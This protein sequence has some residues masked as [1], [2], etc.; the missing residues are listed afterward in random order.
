MMILRTPPESQVWVRLLF[1]PRQR[2]KGWTRRE[3]TSIK[4]IW[5]YQRLSHLH[6]FSLTSSGPLMQ[7]SYEKTIRRTEAV[8]STWTNEAEWVLG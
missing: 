2:A 8:P 7:Q 3:Y 4:N 1:R 5:C 6:A